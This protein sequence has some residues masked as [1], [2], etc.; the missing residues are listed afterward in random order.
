MA[1]CAACLYFYSRRGD[2]WERGSGQ[3]KGA[4]LPTSTPGMVT[5]ER[6][7]GAADAVGVWVPWWDLGEGFFL[8][9]IFC[10]EIGSS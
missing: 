9:C 4:D 6:V 8:L 1:Q 7:E 10:C 3:W 5:G 2:F